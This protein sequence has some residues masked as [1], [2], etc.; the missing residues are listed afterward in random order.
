[1]YEV[2]HL[3][4]FFNYFSD[5]PRGITILLPKLYE[6]CG[7]CIPGTESPTIATKSPCDDSNAIKLN[8]VNIIDI[9]ICQ[10]RCISA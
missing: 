5:I 2:T 10:M 1:M 3:N 7:S 4:S 6:L 8:K 9:S